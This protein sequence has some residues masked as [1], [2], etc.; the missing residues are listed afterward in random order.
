MNSKNHKVLRVYRTKAQAKES[1]DKISRFYDYFA[2]VFEKKYRSMALER[3]DIK[4]GETVLEIGFGTGHCLKRMAE[5][6]GEDGRVYGIDIS[7]GMLEV[8]KRRL[9]EAE[10]LDRV[11][12]YCGDALKMSYEDNEFDAVFMSFT[13]ELFDTPEILK[14]LDE[15]ERVLK[16]NGRFGVISMSKED[17]DS[18]LLRVYEWTHK[19]FPKYADCRPI[20][21]EQSIKNAGFEIEYKEK[22]KLF[23]LPGEIVIGVIPS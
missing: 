14:V 9:E 6:V 4:R 20:Y 2:G 8:S 3:L 19:K 13:L 16:P 18:I 5:S 17:G 22:V 1:Y 12:L 15:I 23:G 10:L 21:I 7:S 11:K